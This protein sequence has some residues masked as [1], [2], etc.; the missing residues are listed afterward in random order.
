MKEREKA[1][2]VSK[3]E[4]VNIDI[5]VTGKVINLSWTADLCDYIIRSL[6]AEDCDID[7]AVDADLDA[8]K[9]KVS[10]YEKN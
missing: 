8:N 3:T 1:D 5:V 9:I 10:V 7:M 2:E 4:L 6:G